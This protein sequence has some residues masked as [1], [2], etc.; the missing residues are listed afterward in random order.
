MVRKVGKEAERIGQDVEREIDTNQPRL[1]RVGSGILLFVLGAGVAA[2][3]LLAVTPVFVGPDTYA[4]GPM[5]PAGAG[6]SNA[7]FSP[8]PVSAIPAG[9]EGEAIKRAIDLFNNT[10]DKAAPFVGNGLACKNCHIDAGRKAGAAPMWAAWVK[11]PEFYA[12]TGAITTMTDRIR[13]CFTNSMNAQDS[14]SGGPPP[15]GSPIYSDLEMYFAWL[16]K[17]APVGAKLQGGGFTMLA[18]PALG[19]DPVRGKA[20]FQQYC[21]ACHGVGGQGAR[22]P[23]GQVVYPPL[24]GPHSYNW[25]AGMAMI[26]LAAA[27]IKA[28]MPFGEKTSQLTDQQAWDVSAYINSQ[29]RPK[30]PTQVGTVAETAAKNFAGVPSYYGKTIDG[31]LLGTGSP[32]S[33]PF[34]KAR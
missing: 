27:F 28:N 8:P 19:Y 3:A 29:E 10:G 12:R 5:G 31:H 33:G 14:P 22:Q 1:T 25:N 26:D 32:N 18:K 4:G 9:P 17:G 20:V 34:P 11:F 15:A 2:I 6:V 21:A 23:N 16:A 24:W 7:S 13:G 30:D